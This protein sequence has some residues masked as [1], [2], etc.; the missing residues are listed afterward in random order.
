M[1]LA[2]VLQ[3]KNEKF[4]ALFEKAGQRSKGFSMP[5]SCNFSPGLLMQFRL[6]L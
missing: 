5:T 6:Q 1:V 2:K 3:Q 4:F